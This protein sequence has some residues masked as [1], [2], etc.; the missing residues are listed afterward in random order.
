MICEFFDNVD[1]AWGFLLLQFGGATKGLQEPIGM[2][3]NKWKVVSYVIFLAMPNFRILGA[4]EKHNP[5]L[6][7][8]YKT[9]WTS[10]ENQEPWPFDSLIQEV[11]QQP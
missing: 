6:L 10:Y 11:T 9:L 8:E 7:Q 5:F 1:E 2:V 3:E 4:K